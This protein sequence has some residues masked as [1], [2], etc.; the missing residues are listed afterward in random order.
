MMVSFMCQL[1]WAMGYPDIGS[2]IVLEIL[3]K[4]FLDE[5]NI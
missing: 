2:N 3:L 1:H 4:V 5:I